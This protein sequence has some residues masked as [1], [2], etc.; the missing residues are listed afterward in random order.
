MG[1]DTK[2]GLPPIRLHD[3]RHTHASLAMLAGVPVKV[4]QERLG[5]STPAITM[6]IYQHTSPGMDAQAAVTVT[7][8]FVEDA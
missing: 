7:D 4:V 2:H 5:H 6:S 8:L 3:T 1:F